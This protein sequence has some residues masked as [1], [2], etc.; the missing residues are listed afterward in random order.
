V[1]A[2]DVRDAFPRARC[3]VLRALE[4]RSGAYSPSFSLYA[5]SPLLLFS[6]DI[7]LP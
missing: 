5:Q 7:F 1:K 4:A 3:G 2:D 6:F